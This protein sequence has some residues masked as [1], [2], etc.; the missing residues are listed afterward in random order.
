MGY[1][2]YAISWNIKTCLVGSIEP[3]EHN[4]KKI[5]ILNLVK[6]GF[7]QEP[8]IFYDADKA[9]KRKSLLMQDFNPAYDELE[10]FEKYI[11]ISK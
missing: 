3:K 4:M 9:K 5:W 1:A 8:E 11:C 6:R 10:I 7:I 2:I